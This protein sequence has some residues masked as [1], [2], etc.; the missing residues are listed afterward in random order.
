MDHLSLSQSNTP[1]SSSPFVPEHWQTA[2]VSSSPPTSPLSAPSVSLCFVY[3]SVVVFPLLLL[4]KCTGTRGSQITWVTPSF[5]AKVRESPWVWEV[6]A[7]PEFGSSGWEHGTGT[8]F[9]LLWDWT[10]SS[11]E[12]AV[13][14]LQTPSLLCFKTRCPCTAAVASSDTQDSTDKGL[15]VLHVA[16]SGLPSYLLSQLRCCYASPSSE[17]A[18]VFW[19]ISM[20]VL[21]GHLSGHWE[22]VSHG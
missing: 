15:V 13:R 6:W 22:A 1:L 2:F 5:A 7:R 11:W 9:V 4:P 18:R 10:L 12:F 19:D 8:W 14:K 3:L 20:G 16:I 21:C 17:H